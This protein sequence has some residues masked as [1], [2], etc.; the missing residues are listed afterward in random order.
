MLRRGC[1]LC[2]ACQPTALL[3]QAAVDALT[4]NLGLEW[5]HY[6]IRTAGAA[7][8]PIE[9]TTGMTELAPSSDAAA[10]VGRCLHTGDWL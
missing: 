5:G 2:V 3:L 1:A 4:R 6:G 10:Q 8:G 7:H 9:G